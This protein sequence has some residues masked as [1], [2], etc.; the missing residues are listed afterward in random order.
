MTGVYTD[1][2]TIDEAVASIRS[3]SYYPDSDGTIERIALYNYTELLLQYWNGTLRVV[4][5]GFVVDTRS[6]FTGSIGPLIDVPVDIPVSAGHQ[7]QFEIDFE[8]EEIPDWHELRNRLTATMLL[9][10]QAGG[11]QP[12]L[13]WLAVG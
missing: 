5:N 7:L 12:P 9:S 10:G 2:W 6:F 11:Y 13:S 1:E 4:R 3:S 8:V